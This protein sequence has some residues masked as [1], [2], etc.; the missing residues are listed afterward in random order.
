MNGLLGTA[1]DAADLLDA[2]GFVVLRKC[3]MGSY[4]AVYVPHA[5]K[6][7]IPLTDAVDLAL[8]WDGKETKEG[9]AFG[10]ES[11]GV[12]MTDGFEVGELLSELTAI[13]TRPNLR[14]AA[15]PEDD[16][17]M[18]EQPTK[19]E[20]EEYERQRDLGT[21]TA[22]VPPPM[23][24][25]APTAPPPAGGE[26]VGGATGG[27]GY[28]FVEIPLAPDSLPYADPRSI[29]DPD[30]PLEHLEP[31]SVDA[32]PE[33]A[34][35]PPPVPNPR[36]QPRRSVPQPSGPGDGGNSGTDSGGD[37]FYTPP[38]APTGTGGW[39]G[40]DTGGGFDSSP[41]FGPGE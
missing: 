11:P 34:T 16:P 24:P 29:I 3:A 25:A 18:D 9:R 5:S 38:D 17:R 1:Q 31:E 12:V 36:P 32:R 6:V 22:P 8:G 7:Y 2:G 10:D 35:N 21:T 4:I 37:V 15:G 23:P 40:P 27:G 39:D 28:Q 41:Q 26:A 20:W 13:A 19:E 33:W 14:L 30:D